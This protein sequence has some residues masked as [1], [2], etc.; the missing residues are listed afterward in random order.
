MPADSINRG[1]KSRSASACPGMGCIGGTAEPTPREGRHMTR[2]TRKTVAIAAVILSRR[3]GGG[4]R[5]ERPACAHRRD[6]ELDER[7]QAGRRQQRR[8][9]G[10]RRRQPADQV[11]FCVLRQAQRRLKMAHLHRQARRSGYSWSPRRKR[12][13]GFAW[14]ERRHGRQRRAL[15]RTARTAGKGNNGDNGSN[16]SNGHDGRDAPGVITTHV[17]GGDSSVCGP[18]W[19]TD[20]Y[21]RTLQIASAGQ[22]HDQRHPVVSRH[23]RDNRRSAGAEWHPAPA[24]RRPVASTACSRA[25]MSS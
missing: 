6:Q 15:A 1:S 12:Q 23:V 18:D 21:S 16:G 19:A 4:L 3:S 25:S 22:R 9:E 20:T 7:R 11:R 10:E 8:S 17:T 13:R 14:Q 2:K 5:R 24:L